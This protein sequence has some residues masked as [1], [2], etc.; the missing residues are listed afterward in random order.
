MRAAVRVGH[1]QV[2]YFLGLST[3]SVSF[4]SLPGTDAVRRCSIAF[5]ES[6]HVTLARPF[7]SL[8]TL[9]GDTSPVFVVKRSAAS[10]IGFP[11]TSFT[12]ATIERSNAR[13]F[14]L[15]ELASSVSSSGGPGLAFAVTTAGAV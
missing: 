8:T 10:G 9:A 5:G 11:Y 14:A 13:V 6:F 2:S 4:T 7:A 12:I 15:A 1:P 3:L